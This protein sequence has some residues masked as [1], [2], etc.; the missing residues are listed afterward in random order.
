MV[1]TLIFPQKFAIL[2]AVLASELCRE[3]TLMSKKTFL[4]SKTVLI[5]TIL[6]FFI[7]SVSHASVT[8]RSSL[9][10]KSVLDD[11]DFKKSFALQFTLKYV[12]EWIFS[13]SVNFEKASKSSIDHFFKEIETNTKNSAYQ[14]GFFFDINYLGYA[15]L[16]DEVI[17]AFSIHEPRETVLILKVNKKTKKQKLISVEEL[18]QIAN[19]AIEK[20]D[21]PA[22]AQILH[23][24]GEIPSIKKIALFIPE[25]E[26]LL[27]SLLPF[28][29]KEYTADLLNKFLKYVNNLQWSASPEDKLKIP[30]LFRRYKDDMLFYFERVSNDLDTASLLIDHLV[31]S[32]QGCKEIVRDIE[33]TRSA[34]Q[35]IL[36]E[37]QKPPEE[38]DFD[39]LIYA[40][41]SCEEFIQKFS[42][43]NLI[44]RLYNTKQNEISYGRENS[45]RYWNLDREIQTRF[46]GFLDASFQQWQAATNSETPA[47]ASSQPKAG[48]ALLYHNSQG[49]LVATLRNFGN[50]FK[51]AELSTSVEGIHDSQN[52]LQLVLGQPNPDRSSFSEPITTIRE[53]VD[54]KQVLEAFLGLKN[55]NNWHI[56]PTLGVLLGDQRLLEFVMRLI[57]ENALQASEAEEISVSLKLKEENANGE[58]MV[59]IEV[60]NPLPPGK[61]IPSNPFSPG[62][63]DKAPP[64]WGMGLALVQKII[65]SWQ[66]TASLKTEGSSALCQIE[67]PVIP[68]PKKDRALS[69][70]AIHTLL[71]ELMQTETLF[72]PEELS[73]KLEKLFVECILEIDLKD[74][75]NSLH[76]IDKY[77]PVYLREKR[78]DFNLSQKIE[79]IYDQINKIFNQTKRYDE[80]FLKIQLEVY[81]ALEKVL[82]HIQGTEEHEE[83]QAELYL[84]I[85]KILER[86]SRHPEKRE[87]YKKA[88]SYYEK[89]KGT[90]VGN[91]L[92]QSTLSFKD[93]LKILE[94]ICAPKPAGYHEST[95]VAGGI[96]MEVELFSSENRSNDI[97]FEKLPTSKLKEIETKLNAK[98]QQE[99]PNAPFRIQMDINGW[100]IISHL[101]IVEPQ[102]QEKLPALLREVQDRMLILGI[103]FLKRELASIIREDPTLQEELKKIHGEW[104]SEVIANID[105]KMECALSNFHINKSEEADASDKNLQGLPSLMNAIFLHNFRS[106]SDGQKYKDIRGVDSADPLTGSDENYRPGRNEILLSYAFSNQQQSGK[107][108]YLA[109]LNE[110]MKA[111]DDQEFDNLKATINKRFH[112]K[113][114]GRVF[115]EKLDALKVSRQDESPTIDLRELYFSIPLSVLAWYQKSDFGE[116]HQYEDPNLPVLG[117]SAKQV[118]Q[119]L[120]ELRNGG[121]SRWDKPLNSL[122]GKTF[123]DLLR[124]IVKDENFIY[125][126]LSYYGTLEEYLCLVVIATPQGPDIL[127]LMDES[128]PTSAS[129]P[130]SKDLKPSK[131]LDRHVFSVE[132]NEKGYRFYPAE[133][134][135]H[136][137]RFYDNGILTHGD[138]SAVNTKGHT[139]S[140]F[141]LE[142]PEELAQDEGR[143]I[144]IKLHEKEKLNRAR[145]VIREGIEFQTLN[146]LKLFL[147]FETSESPVD[148]QLIEIDA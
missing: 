78:F 6:I 64:R 85:G 33:I 57:L 123:R 91:F 116:N 26:T 58:R 63:T 17:V 142:V 88:I 59:V 119:C 61:E 43:N 60:K 37:F 5:L 67:F 118:N 21:I 44:A 145:Q 18:I 95:F 48:L 136:C 24:L 102:G 122:K 62:V 148:Q 25:K 3:Y 32:E 51:L 101:V 69:D 83:I 109:P 10:P 72:E 75:E 115:V 99:I 132:S 117:Y 73:H 42:A 81:T 70:V 16:Q 113:P 104:I 137:I 143:E 98:L 35:F 39:R 29:Q 121:K 20:Q 74:A 97:L 47:P 49:S 27:L 68:Y 31:L 36:K 86:L 66:G 41:Y 87:Y 56:D 90:T 111:V 76:I 147:G 89:H 4:H 105:Q 15:H 129:L 52:H 130:S 144:V 77:L 55:I 126:Y 12:A 108:I 79:T 107:P 124:F 23:V 7:L 138:L 94:R 134:D 112:S 135:P 114:E 11:P 46:E 71:D 80:S 127:E 34:I 120:R 125:E 14:L 82:N 141:V 84:R 13:G 110:M 1:L 65:E 92:E 106:G 45:R 93:R 28:L 140:H 131:F 50:A 139:I 146:E 9:A 96:E 40:I 103:P 22:I 100:E 128:A 38:M 19:D 54:L 30:E 8:T 2:N 133:N 53:I